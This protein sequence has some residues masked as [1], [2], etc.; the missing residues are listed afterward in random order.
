VAQSFDASAIR[1]S[2]A[3]SSLQLRNT[4]EGSK[5]TLTG[6]WKGAVW[7]DIDGERK[8]IAGRNAQATDA[9]ILGGGKLV[10]Y[11]TPDGAGGYEN[12]GQALRVYDV[13]S[14]KSKKVLAEYFH[15]DKMN[16]VRLSDGRFALLAAMSDGGLGADH[17]AVVD[18]TRGEVYR[19][20]MSKRMGNPEGDFINVGH[21]EPANY[22]TY[23]PDLSNPYE[24][25]RLDLKEVLNREVIVLDPT[26]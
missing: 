5:A 11:A 2:S 10:A 7:A 24:V 1:R 21:F 15:I 23:P 26:N 8:V 19:E 14:G 17:F 6:V 22:E 18:P 16:S 20:G 4:D 25:T 9:W 13:D 12:E 3:L